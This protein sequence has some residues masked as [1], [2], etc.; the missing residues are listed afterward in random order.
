MNRVRAS[1]RS[2][3]F[4]HRGVR[5]FSQSAINER[6]EGAQL[7]CLPG[8]E[9]L[10]AEE[11]PV[12]KLCRA[13]LAPQRGFL[14]ALSRIYGRELESHASRLVLIQ[15]VGI[16]GTFLTDA[17]YRERALERFCQG[18]LSGP[19]FVMSH[20]PS[21]LWRALDPEARFRLHG[22]ADRDL[23]LC[24]LLGELGWAQ[25]CDDMLRQPIPLCVRPWSPQ[26][27]LLRP[28]NPPSRSYSQSLWVEHVGPRRLLLFDKRIR[29]L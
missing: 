18:L 28:A 25:L 24:M 16:T 15:C 19:A 12:L 27:G 26:H 7:T 17:A 21:T 11:N 6:F 1:W 4:D 20:A 23:L 13:L 14:D 22:A 2:R 3:D 29:G 8:P 9:G 10:G 5:A